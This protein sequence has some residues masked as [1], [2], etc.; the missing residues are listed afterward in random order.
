MIKKPSHP[1]LYG[2]IETETG[3]MTTIESAHA[4]I[5]AGEGFSLSVVF[6]AVANGASVNYCFKT[7]LAS[8]GV[9][10]HTQ[11][12]DISATNNKITAELYEAPTNAPTSGSAIV[13]Y[14]RDRNSTAT[15]KLQSLVSGATINTTGA[16]LLNKR[17]FTSSGT[18]SFIEN[19]FKPDTWYIRQFTNGT[20][21]ASDISL[22]TFWC[23]Y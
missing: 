23:E 21:S 7:P 3:F 15:T 12:V 8:S 2:T 1:N 6:E 14:N 20:G 22:F 5:H 9:H 13:A 18:S 19:I 4:H 11:L 16:A 17:I 10:V